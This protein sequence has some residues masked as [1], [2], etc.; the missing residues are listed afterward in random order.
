M[1]VVQ[2][3]FQF[4]MIM[5]SLSSVYSFLFLHFQVSTVFSISAIFGLAVY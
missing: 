5:A 1:E 4:Q 3:G 2:K